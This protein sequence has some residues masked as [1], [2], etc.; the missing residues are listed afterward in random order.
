MGPFWSRL[1]DWHLGLL[2]Q[3]PK[4]WHTRELTLV[5]AELATFA[6]YAVIPLLIVYFLVRRQRV[7]FSRV[8]FL[9]LLYLL[10]GG[11][12]HVLS[13]FGEPAE[14]WAIRSEERRVGKV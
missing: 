14:S 7:H 6:A 13:A 8:W 9:L 2:A 12:V 3:T 1:V 4:V 5:F 10:V 11:T